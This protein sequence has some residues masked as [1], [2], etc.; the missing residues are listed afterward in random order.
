MPLIDVSGGAPPVDQSIGFNFRATAG[1]VTDDPTD[2]YAGPS[3]TYP[4]VHIN[5]NGVQTDAGYVDATFANGN[6][7]AVA[8]PRLAGNHAVTGATKFLRWQVAMPPGNYRAFLG[9]GTSD[10]PGNA[11]VKLYESLWN[12]GAPPAATPIVDRAIAT[13]AGQYQNFAV[14]GPWNAA[15]WSDNYFDYGV[16]IVI[17]DN[18]IQSGVT[19]DCVGVGSGYAL[20]AHLRVSPR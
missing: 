17:A 13:S 6:N 9:H 10:F 20:I 3:V 4:T 19:L 5:A 7:K 12:S 11:T 15:G 1:H 14:G 18:G 2:V 16:D 8:D